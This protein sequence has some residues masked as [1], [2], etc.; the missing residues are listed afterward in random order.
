MA[1]SLWESFLVFL[2]CTAGSQID[3]NP[4]KKYS[5][6]HTRATYMCYGVFDIEC[7]LLVSFFP[8]AS[9][10]PNPRRATPQRMAPSRL[11]PAES[12]PGTAALLWEGGLGLASRR[13]RHVFHFRHVA[14]SFLREGIT[15]AAGAL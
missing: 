5:V 13:S 8:L 12:D 11:S 14:L 10:P 1:L 9:L 2:H 7:K 3:P 4:K 6:P 15:A